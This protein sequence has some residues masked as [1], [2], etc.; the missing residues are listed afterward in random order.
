MFSKYLEM[1]LDPSV[2][3]FVN[4]V[5]SINEHD[6]GDFMRAA[7]TYLNEFR[8]S[9]DR[10]GFFDLGNQFSKMQLYL[11]FV[12]NWDVNSTR[13]KLLVDAEYLNDLLVA[14]QPQEK[15]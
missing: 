5:N 9:C 15:F 3:K 8:L 13:T 11:Q 7:N 2:K 6:Y 10:S 14:H 4:Q 12:P 1:P